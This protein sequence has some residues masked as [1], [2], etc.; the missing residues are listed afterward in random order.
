MAAGGPTYTRAGDTATQAQQEAATRL[1]CRTVSDPVARQ[2]V[3]ESLGLMA[4]SN[5]VEVGYARLAAAIA[6]AEGG[7]DDAGA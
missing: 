6:G 3:L 2:D 5:P 1:V 4:Y 7:G